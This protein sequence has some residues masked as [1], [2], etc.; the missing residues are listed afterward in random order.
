MKL[1][2]LAL[3]FCLAVAENSNSI[4]DLEKI[5]SSDSQ[6]PDIGNL[7]NVDKLEALMQNKLKLKG[8][9]YCMD[10]KTLAEGP[11]MEGCPKRLCYDKKTLQCRKELGKLSA[12]ERFHLCHTE[13]ITYRER[14]PYTCGLCKPR[15]PV[16]ECRKIHGATARCCSNGKP[17]LKPDKSDCEVC[18]NNNPS[19]CERFYKFLGGKCETSAYLV[20]RYLYTNCPKRCGRCQ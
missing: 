14:C 6:L 15:N 5:L 17:A 12:K 16:Q 11:G 7:E 9:K 8:Y 2:I 1:L 10:G 4:E 19:L 18:S 13:Y 3:C 20:R